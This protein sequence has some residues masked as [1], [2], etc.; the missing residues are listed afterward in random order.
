MRLQRSAKL[1]SQLNRY[2][3]NIETLED[4][5]IPGNMLLG[6][7]GIE[8]PFAVS[9][10]KTPLS[11]S[12]AVSNAISSLK[13]SSTTAQ[14]KFELIRAAAK[15]MVNGIFNRSIQ[16]GRTAANTSI[17]TSLSGKSA[18]VNM[19][20]RNETYEQVVQNLT[21]LLNAASGTQN[22]TANTL[23]LMTNSIKS[24]I[25]GVGIVPSNPRPP[26]PPAN[27]TNTSPN[28]IYNL[29]DGDSG[30]YDT[31]SDLRQNSPISTLNAS[32]LQGEALL[33]QTATDLNYTVDSVFGIPSSM[34]NLSS[35]LT[36]PRV[37]SAINIT[38]DFISQNAQFLGISATDVNTLRD[39]GSYNW[40]TGGGIV[41]LQQ[42]VNNRPVIGTN[43]GSAVRADGSLVILNNGMIPNVSSTINATTPVLTAQQAILR[44]AQDAGLT[45]RGTLAS[46]TPRGVEQV[47]TFI[48]ASIS[49]DP[50]PVSLQY[51]PIGPGETR[52]VYNTRI[53]I[54]GSAYMFEYNIDAVTGHAWNRTNW[55]AGDSYRVF[56]APVSN[57][58]DGS[59]TLVVNPADP[60]ASPYG[61]H[62]INGRTGAE[63]FYT[64]G[65]NTSTIWAPLAD[66]EADPP[67]LN[68]TPAFG[69][70][71]NNYDFPLNV[72]L[73]PNSYSNSATT[74]LFYAVN[75]FHDVTYRAGF[76]EVAGNF[77]QN[78]YGRGPT[79]SQNDPIRAFAQSGSQIGYS[80]NAFFAPTPDGIAPRTHFFIWAGSAG[81]RDTDLDNDIIFHE[82]GH[83]IST[84][85]VGGPQY[86]GSL[87]QTFEGRGLGE[88]WADYMAL[89]LG[90][91]QTDNKTTR[92]T[93][94][95]WVQGQ[96][97]A[98][99]G[100]RN[101]PYSYNQ[102][103][104]PYTYSDFD[105]QQSSHGDGNGFYS[106]YTMGE[107]WANALNDFTLNMTENYGY[108]ADMLN[109]D[110]GNNR[111]FKLVVAAMALTPYAPSSIEARNALV[112]ADQFQYGGAYQREIWDAM[113]RRGL[114]VRAI[115]ATPDPDDPAEN[116]PVPWT[117][118]EDFTQ[119]DF[120]NVPPPP[121]PP[122][123]NGSNDNFY[124]PNETS[125]RAFDL[126]TLP[127]GATSV[128]D[129]QIK[130]P[131][132]GRAQD[133]DWFKFT[134]TSA[135]I[136][137]IN[138]DVATSAGDID[139][140][141][142]RSKNGS[143]TALTKIGQG[144]TR[145]RGASE[146]VNIA[147][148]AGITYYFAVA[149]YNNGWGNY[150]INITAP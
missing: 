139:L 69:V 33:R 3:P 30:G 83:G 128:D 87:S 27:N 54:P 32:Q 20:F 100:I 136:L 115:A 97:A 78:N 130:Q 147:V 68:G 85:L 148:G 47:P 141:V 149:G 63:Y 75:Y 118:Q 112:A 146:T 108:N 58:G 14:D 9:G 131:Q 70:G 121:P 57:P 50:I 10:Q 48:N 1:V 11:S 8:L 24:S 61:W 64:R 42:Y 7:S 26:A 5:T 37:G 29:A 93:V 23:G 6:P 21:S 13:T 98:G 135:G 35:P 81:V 28:S 74:Q 92:Q 72:A 143:P 111:A 59:R 79:T 41:H 119:P 80:N 88:G 51:L 137:T 89:V 53:F 55:V 129:L 34:I 2:K 77:Q 110:A 116:P 43:S 60:V 109:G 120:T 62:D 12:L 102:V 22:G 15:Q 142:Y 127:T 134:A 101:Y 94:G 65:N 4:R 95:N 122:G 56:Q 31:R 103:I 44:A 123:G 36:G 76:N 49:I 106:Y 19:T 105:Q 25:G 133:R 91:K 67:I 52:L 117:L 82:L 114:G 38:K 66:H 145:T 45:V 99:N 84:R 132:A 18:G 16:P 107:I 71:G 40:S 124:E 39:V 90:Q 104:S 73:H 113:A 125:N 96:N 17:D 144:V 86:A 138:V 126:G 150:N 140:Y 46:T